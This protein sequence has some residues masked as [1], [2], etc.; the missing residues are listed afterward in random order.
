[1]GAPSGWP[2]SGEANY[3]SFSLCYFNVHVKSCLDNAFC[4]LYLIDI[5][6]HLEGKNGQEFTRVEFIFIRWFS[7]SA[8]TDL[9]YTDGSKTLTHCHFLFFISNQDWRRRERGE[10]KKRERELA[11][12]R[13]PVL[14]L[15]RVPWLPERSRHSI[16]PARPRQWRFII[17]RSSMLLPWSFQREMKLRRWLWG[18]RKQWGEFVLWCHRPP[19]N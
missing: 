16:R 11:V 9:H 4:R 8:R 7:L 2:V 6:R 14:P 5:W 1:M 10:K 18:R 15:V 17:S 12:N 19:H 3:C 13:L